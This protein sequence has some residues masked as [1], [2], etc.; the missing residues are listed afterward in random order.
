MEKKLQEKKTTPINLGKTL[1]W[2]YF[3]YAEEKINE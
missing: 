3:K 2:D 1:D